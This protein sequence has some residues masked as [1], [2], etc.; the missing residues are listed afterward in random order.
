MPNFSLK[1][2]QN[3][4]YTNWWIWD[5]TNNLFITSRTIPLKLSDTKEVLFADITV[6]GLNYTPLQP[7]RNGSAKLSFQLPIINRL[8]AAGNSLQLSQFENLRNQDSPSLLGLLQPSSQF[9]TNPSVIYN[10]GTHRTPLRY[11]VTK[12]SFD[13]DTRLTS[14]IGLAQYTMVDMELTLDENSALYRAWIIARKVAS[15]AGFVQGTQQT[16]KPKG[17]RPY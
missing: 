6:P 7:N 17:N 11:W 8:T 5:D 4:K 14:K 15:I 10:W 12:C 13:N 16:F 1:A 2:I 3:L 9:R